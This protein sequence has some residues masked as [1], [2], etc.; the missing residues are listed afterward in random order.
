MRDQEGILCIGEILWDALPSGLYLGGAP[1][2]VCYHLKQFDVDAIVS[3]RVGNDRLGLEAIR[4]IK[5]KGINTNYIQKDYEHETGFVSVELSQNGE[6]EY[7]INEPVAWDFVELTDLL[8]DL[9]QNCWGIVFGSLAQRNK[10]SRVTIQKMWDLNIKKIFDMNIRPPYID[11][12]IINQSLT[13]SDIVKMNE[14]ELN[15][16][17]DWYGLSSKTSKAVE[18]LAAKFDCSLFCITCGANGSIIFEDGTWIE[19]KG[20][21]VKVA[22]VVGA[23]DAF[24]AALLYGINSGWE[25]EKI[26]SFANATGAFVAQKQGATPDYNKAKIKSIININR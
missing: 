10:V 6:P 2:N 1:L 25:Y 16:L 14:D 8:C 7:M 22:D 13:V 4:R 20:Y 24:L 11:K 21:P 23:G 15:Q 9:A 17:K 26:L 19:H 5:H 3:S 18:E 12:D